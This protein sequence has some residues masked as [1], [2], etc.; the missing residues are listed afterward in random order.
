MKGKVLEVG[1]WVIIATLIV[2]IIDLFKTNRELESSYESYKKDGTYVSTYQSKT[3]SELKKQNRELYDSIKNKKDV[4]QAVIIKYKYKYEGETIYLDRKLPIPK[5]SI[6]TFQKE[7]DTV[8]YTAKVKTA[9]KPEW[10]N[11]NFNINDKLVLINREKNGQN[12]L[13]IST[14]GGEIDGTVS[15][16]KEDNK[17]NFINRF[18]LGVNAGVGYGLISKKPDIYVGVGVSFRLNKK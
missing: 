12:E 4:K 5:D 6:Y 13:T 1:K 8:S 15:F 17:D 7:T 3:I 18:S 11:V 10:L 9:S 2:L 16:N 14:N